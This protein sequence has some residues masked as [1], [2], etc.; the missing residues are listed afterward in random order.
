MIWPSRGSPEKY[1]R[2]N[3]WVVRYYDP[4]AKQCRSYRTKHEHYADVFMKGL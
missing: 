1:R 4:V 2:A 3:V